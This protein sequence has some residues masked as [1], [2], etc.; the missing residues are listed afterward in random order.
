MTTTNLFSLL[1]LLGLLLSGCANQGQLREDQD[2]TGDLGSEKR[3]SPAQIYVEMGIAY[4]Q[5]GQPAVALQRLKKAISI[6]PQNSEAHNVIAILYE[7]LGKTELAREHY[8]KAAQL[9]P[10][11]P[12]IRNARGSFFCNQG[13]YEEAE[14]EYASALSNPLY[15][16]PSVAMTNAGICAERMGDRV[17]AEQYYRRALTANAEYSQ[18]LYQMAELSLQ[19]G[20]P[21]SARGY[22]ERYNAVADPTAG[23]LW[24][25]V[26]IERRLGDPRKASYYQEQ[27]LENFPDAP[28]VQLLNQSR[29]L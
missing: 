6:D 3:E 21:L 22:L 19:Q 16:T 12:Y 27:L 7:R 5:D 25:G 17:K 10:Q 14:A 1:I 20:N 8:D 23:S 26:Q 24:L 28:E 4:L 15:P 29:P 9:A 2:T 11:N 13:L 18:A